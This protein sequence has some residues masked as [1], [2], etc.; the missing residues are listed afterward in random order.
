VKAY[1]I[2]SPTGVNDI[3]RIDLPEPKARPG[4]VVVR[5][6]ANSL[7]FRDLVIAKGGYPRNEKQPV[8]PVSDM[9]GEVVEVGDGVDA[10]KVGDRVA[11]NFMRDWVSGPVNEKV[12][13][14]SLGGGVEGTLAEFVALPAASLMRVPE[15]LSYA[16]GAALVCAGLTAWNAL[17][18][19]NT[20]AGD[21][22]LL[23]GTGGVSVFGLQFA[24]ALGARAIIT[25]SD[26]AKI[27]RLASL[28]PD[29]TINYRTTTEWHEPAR[30]FTEG[31]GVD[32][33]L[34]VGGPGTFERSIKA[35]RV[36]GTISLIGFLAQDN[37]PPI[38]PI[39]LNALTV[40]GIYVG[41]V[42]MF[43]RMNRVVN[44]HKIRPVIDRSFSFDDAKAAYAYFES[45]KHLGKVVIEH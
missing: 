27:E 22:V 1:Q 41:S 42:E 28:K 20:R 39:I 4:E 15:H 36:G 25:S 38:V 13:W 31:V 45:Q 35:T 10:W 26:D 40:R 30:S 24:K 43:E 34:E 12:L 11:A 16:E 44:A 32:H 2:D 6:R 21:T 17:E 14:S 29:L 19:A 8:V 33:V 9:A 23:L 37:P 3:K 7:N 18:S 5:V